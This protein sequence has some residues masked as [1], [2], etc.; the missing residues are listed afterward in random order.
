[1]LQAAREGTVGQ[2]TLEK[3]VAA[4]HGLTLVSNALKEDNANLK[5]HESSH[6]SFEDFENVGPPDAIE[7]YV[8]QQFPRRGWF[9]S[10]K[11]QDDPLSAL[12]IDKPIHIKLKY[13]QRHGTRKKHGIHVSW[14]DNFDMVPSPNGLQRSNTLYEIKNHL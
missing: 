8:P 12:D 5:V 3:I 10:F 13:A 1:M 7:G 14:L 11:E 4:V 6:S 9:S 2:E